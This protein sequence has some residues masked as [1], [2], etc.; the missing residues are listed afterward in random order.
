MMNFIAKFLV[1]VHTFL[2]ITAMAVAMAFVLQGRDFGW[3]EPYTQVVEY[4]ADGSP[5]AS[6]RYASEYDKSWAAVTEAG[7]TRDRTYTYVKP[8]IE[9]LRTTEPFLATN[10]LHFVA[11]LDR[12]KKGPGKIDIFRLEKRGTELDVAVLGKPKRE[13]NPIADISQS[14]TT[15][16]ADL[17]DLYEKIGVVDNE[18]KKIVDETKTITS[19]LTGTDETNKY[20]HPGLYQL[21]EME[22]AA[23]TKLKTEIEEIKP[24]WSK[25]V[26]RAR[27]DSFRRADLEA[28]LEKLK[29]ATQP[30]DNKKK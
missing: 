22:F 28:T 2:S 25:A 6:V 16:W 30:Q 12:L 27:L 8:A 3:T 15:Y 11:E 5:K 9:T 24:G 10:Y 1:L 19:Q 4:G 21:T 20:L 23:Q 18:I 29:A 26:E 7:K 13:G 17:Q 14:Y